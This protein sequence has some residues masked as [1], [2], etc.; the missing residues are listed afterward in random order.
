M[1]AKTLKDFIEI[2]RDLPDD[3]LSQKERLMI[4]AAMEFK[5]LKVSD[6][7]TPREKVTFVNIRDF[8][9]PLTL[10]RLYRS[11]TSIFPVVDESGRQVVGVLSTDRLNSL[12]IRD[13]DTAEKYLDPRVCY[14]REDYSLEQ[15]VA[16]FIRTHGYFFVVVNKMGQLTGTLNFKEIVGMIMGYYPKDDFD[17]DASL[18]AVIRRKL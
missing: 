18:G 15:A 11:G 17:Q 8:L 3:V 14:L 7:M 13:N 6:V 2:L 1:E 9:G 5:N 16:A 10:D 4:I 12:E